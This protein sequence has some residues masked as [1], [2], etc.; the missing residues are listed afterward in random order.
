LSSLC[1]ASKYTDCL[2]STSL[3]ELLRRFFWL[4][5]KANRC[6]DYP[7]FSS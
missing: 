1:L 2:P 5:S 4:L 7:R 3:L 6:L